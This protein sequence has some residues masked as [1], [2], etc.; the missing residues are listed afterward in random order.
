MLQEVLDDFA[1]E[2][3]DSDR[4]GQME[5]VENVPEHIQEIPEPENEISITSKSVAAEVVEDVLA[6]ELDDGSNPENGSP[7]AKSPNTTDKIEELPVANLVD[8]ISSMVAEN[9]TEK[10]DADESS[11]AAKISAVTEKP[12]AQNSETSDAI[13]IHDSHSDPQVQAG[14][15]NNSNS[16]VDASLPNNPEALK[17]NKTNNIDT[18]ANNKKAQESVEVSKSSGKSSIPKKI[19]R[20]RSSVPEDNLNTIDKKKK[21]LD[22]KGPA[23]ADERVTESHLNAEAEDKIKGS[24]DVIKPDVIKKPWLEDQPMD[25]DK[26]STSFE[27][28]VVDR[29]ETEK[30]NKSKESPEIKNPCLQNISLF[31]EEFNKTRYNMSES[32]DTEQNKKETQAN[33]LASAST[34]S[35]D[36]VVL[37]SNS[38]SSKSDMEKTRV[39]PK[40]K[41]RPGVSTNKSERDKAIGNL[42]GFTSGKLCVGTYLHLVSS[43]VVIK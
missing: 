15:L 42:F 12:V 31:D 9:G 16:T 25:L 7:K 35:N 37:K 22:I 39:P 13:V 3:E 32:S 5:I 26:P 34:P 19:A 30:Q 4:E 41:Q 14:G 11:E 23:N 27:V 17:N 24:E 36:V 20:K 2:P 21:K 10:D 40:K 6:H 1:S 38:S 29:I 8:E 28:H 43:H 18:K 33:T